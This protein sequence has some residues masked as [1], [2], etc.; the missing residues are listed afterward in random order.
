MSSVTA[1]RSL[2]AVGGVLRALTLKLKAEE[3]P[4]LPAASV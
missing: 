1:V 3:T 4:V 2:V